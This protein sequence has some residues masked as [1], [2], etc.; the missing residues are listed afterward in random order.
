MITLV[1]RVFRLVLKLLIRTVCRDYDGHRE[2]KERK[3][4]MDT[5]GK[6]PATSAWPSNDEAR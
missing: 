4:R 2:R 3:R 1:H 5:L 6:Y